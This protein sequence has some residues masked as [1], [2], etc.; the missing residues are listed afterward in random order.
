MTFYRIPRVGV[1]HL[2]MQNDRA[3]RCKVCNRK[4]NPRWLRECDFPL[5]NGKT[6]SLLMC[7]GCAQATGPNTDLCPVHVI[8]TNKKAA[9]A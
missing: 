5:P 3:R 8:E 2:Y 7:S 9:T 6:C 4:T 1:V